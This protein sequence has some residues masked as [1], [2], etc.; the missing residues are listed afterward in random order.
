MVEVDVSLDGPLFR[1]I[2]RN[3]AVDAFLREAARDVTSQLYSEVMGNLN[4]SIREPTPYYETQITVTRNGDGGGRVHDRDIVYGPWLEGTGSRNRPRPGFPGYA[5]FRR[6]YQQVK[7]QV[8]RLV[9]AA[10]RRAIA[11]LGGG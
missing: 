5:S 7:P 9:Q 2:Q 11:R 8:P 3:A 4:A 10:L 6:A 1:D